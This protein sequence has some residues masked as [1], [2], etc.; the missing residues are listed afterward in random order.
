MREE[1]GRPCARAGLVHRPLCA[2]YAPVGEAV[3]AAQ[4]WPAGGDHFALWL[5][6]AGGAGE[7]GEGGAVGGARPRG[8]VVVLVAGKRTE[9]KGR[10]GQG[11]EACHLRLAYGAD[12]GCVNWTGP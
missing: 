12:W 5:V 6:P 1:G 11:Q 3:R 8:L 4:G 9:R 10:K 2:M 7:C